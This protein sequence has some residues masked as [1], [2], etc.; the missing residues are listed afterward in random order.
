[1]FGKKKMLLQIEE[2]TNM[3]NTS[4]MIATGS[5][6]GAGVASLVSIGSVVLG[7]RT[8]KIIEANNEIVREEIGK[9]NKN[10]D[11]NLSE[12]R[13]NIA[14]SIVELTQVN[15]AVAGNNEKMSSSDDG[16]PV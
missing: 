5:A 11:S 7:C 9:M 2:V 15:K 10:I 13:T 8:R 16:E 3:A 14:N 1:M 12:M 6:I 4:K